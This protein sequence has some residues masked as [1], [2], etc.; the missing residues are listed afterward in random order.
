MALKILHRV[1]D[2]LYTLTSYK[3]VYHTFYRRIQK[4]SVSSDIP[5]PLFHN[6]KS[7]TTYHPQWE[8][9]SP[10]FYY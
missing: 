6:L 3:Y 8:N 9:I 4:N 7:L 5:V 10:V 1:N 2:K